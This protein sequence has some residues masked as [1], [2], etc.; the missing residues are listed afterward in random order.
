MTCAD[1]AHF[2][3]CSR[4]GPVSEENNCH[5]FLDNKSII[6]LPCELGSK[7]YGVNDSEVCEYT[8]EAFEYRLKGDFILR[9]VYHMPFTLGEDA[10][11]TKEEAEA[12]LAKK[13]KEEYDER[14]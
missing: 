7:F 3:M 13:L 12:A 6:K 1:C 2:I 10:F 4:C 9:T 8:V 14:K 11:L 5:Q